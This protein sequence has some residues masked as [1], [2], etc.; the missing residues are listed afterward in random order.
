MTRLLV[1]VRSASEAEAALRGGAGLIDVKEPAN[2]PLGKADDAVI[3]QVVRLVAGR[4][5]VSAAMGEAHSAASS[6][7]GSAV[8]GLTYVKFGLAG[9]GKHNGC[10]PADSACRRHSALRSYPGATEVLAAYADATHADSP[11]VDDVCEYVRK[12]TGSV[13]LL[14]TFAKNAGKNLLDWLPVSKLL[15]L[16]ELCRSSGV[17]TALAGSLRPED[18]RKVLFMRPDWIAVRGAACE[19]GRGGVVSEAKVR[20]LAALINSSGHES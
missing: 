15:S 10:S 16:C 14:D 19:G 5:P 6:Y 4:K 20:E 2:G 9:S 8:R 13:F 12:Q 11:P 3:A 1:S 17:Q 7:R 18:I